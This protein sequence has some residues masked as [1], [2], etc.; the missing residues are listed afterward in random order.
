MKTK[1]GTFCLRNNLSTAV[2][3]HCR[4][5]RGLPTPQIKRESSPLPSI[6]PFLPCPFSLSALLVTLAMLLRLINCRFI[7]IFSVFIAIGS[8]NPE[9]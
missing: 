5:C 2:Q 6:R 4:C 8:I 3:L 1:L 7:T 9:G